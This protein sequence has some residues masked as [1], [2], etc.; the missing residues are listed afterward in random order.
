MTSN[1]NDGAVEKL[2]ALNRHQS[3]FAKH[4]NQLLR[5]MREI[6]DRSHYAAKFNVD[7][8]AIRTLT[9]RELEV[10]S[11]CLAVKIRMNVKNVPKKQVSGP[12][13]QTYRVPR[14]VVTSGPRWVPSCAP[15][16][17]ASRVRCPGPCAYQPHHP[18]SNTAPRFCAPA[19]AR[20]VIGSADAVPGP[21]AYFTAGKL[22]H[23]IGDDAPRW[24]AAYRPRLPECLDRVMNPG[25]GAYDTTEPIVSH[26]A[27][28]SIAQT[29]RESAQLSIR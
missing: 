4:S 26:V 13:P 19:R 25:P 9:P 10:L 2:P 27:P 23:S 14:E 6:T 15:P 17:E 3:T 1:Q 7:E 8:R 28:C 12:G 16:L 20:R 11:E 21:G 24:T 22:P 18:A 29:P 5:M